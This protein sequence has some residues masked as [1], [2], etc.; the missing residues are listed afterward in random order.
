MEKYEAKIK[1]YSSDQGT[2]QLTEDILKLVANDDF[3]EAVLKMARQFLHSNDAAII[4]FYDNNQK[5][6]GIKSAIGLESNISEA[7]NLR[8]G[9][10][11]CNDVFAMGESLLLNDPHE[12]KRD[13]AKIVGLLKVSFLEGSNDLIPP[14]SI[15]AI[16]IRGQNK[17][18]GV[19]NLL[20]YEGT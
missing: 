17:I 10:S 9:Q 18:Y 20:R 3:Y 15:M 5:N 13:F 1:K 19:V 14:V 8:L 7:V 12:I 4:Y 6:I 2:M 11:F 16:P